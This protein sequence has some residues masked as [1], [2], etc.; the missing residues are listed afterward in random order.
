MDE[1]KRGLKSLLTDSVLE[2]GFFEWKR[3]RERE[4]Y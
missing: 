4:K 3:E 1:T 2:V